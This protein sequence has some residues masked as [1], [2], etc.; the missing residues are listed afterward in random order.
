MFISLNIWNAT[1]HMSKEYNIYIY[2]RSYIRM[3]S[4]PTTGYQGVL[5]ELAIILVPQNAFKQNQYGFWITKIV[6]HRASKCR[7][8]VL[9]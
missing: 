7:P 6:Q 1:T 5:K 8:H 3:L 4:L 2:I 9:W